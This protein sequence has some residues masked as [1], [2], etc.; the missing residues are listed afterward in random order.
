MFSITTAEDSILPT[1]KN[2]VINRASIHVST[3]ALTHVIFITS[4]EYLH[5]LSTNKLQDYCHD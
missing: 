3:R 1:E 2:H 5:D 4:H